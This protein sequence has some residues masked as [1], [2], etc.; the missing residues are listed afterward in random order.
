MPAPASLAHPLRLLSSAAG[1]LGPPQMCPGD[2]MPLT[3]FQP[4]P[5]RYP[6][7]D[8]YNQGMFAEG[9]Q[10]LGLPHTCSNPSYITQPT[11][12]VK[13]CPLPI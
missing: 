4:P 12:H 1:F 6:A 10:C 9:F 13:A 5:S 7:W 2:Y 3:L 8:S 11:Q